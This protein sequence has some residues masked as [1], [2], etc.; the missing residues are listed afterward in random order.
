MVVVVRKKIAALKDS[1]LIA[2][3][4]ARLEKR[5]G[6]VSDFEKRLG[7]LRELR[8]TLV[9]LRGALVESGLPVKQI[10][11]AFALDNNERRLLLKKYRGAGTETAGTGGETE[12]ESD[13]I[14]G[15]DTAGQG[16][17]SEVDAGEN[18]SAGEH[19][20]QE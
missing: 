16:S 3:D 15:E 18:G 2:P 12:T 19:F 11:E 4:Y 6:A 5:I 14:T 13:S 1:P 7:E 8:A 20:Q 17:Q 9:D 10:V